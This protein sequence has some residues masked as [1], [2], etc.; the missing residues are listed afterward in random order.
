MKKQILA[1]FFALLAALATAAES[2]S[3][4][5]VLRDDQG[6]ALDNKNVVIEFRLYT[7]PTSDSAI[8][9]RSYAI[10]LDNDGLFNVELTDL[11]GSSISG[12]DATLDTALADNAS[13]KLYIGLTV[14][15]SSGEIRPRQ[16][17]LSVPV[18]S[19][20]RNVKNANGNFT[21]SGT[22]VLLASATV[23]EN[24][25]V[26]GKTTTRTLQVDDSTKLTGP[27]EV[28]GG[29]TVSDPNTGLALAA[30]TPFTING[31]SAVI[32]S[33]LIAIWSGSSANIPTGWAL[34]DGSNGTPDLRDRFVLGA[35]PNYPVAAQGGEY[36]HKLTVNEMPAHTHHTVMYG[37]DLSASWDDDNYFY[38]TYAK[39]SKNYNTPETTAT[40]GNA[41]H[42]NMPPYYALCYIMKK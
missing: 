1:S 12:L 38:T 3:Y 42:N 11:S 36:T 33:G 4:Q 8:W 41:P 16:Q 5:G 17:V 40:G 29:M 25:A 10:L 19:F 7:D 2:F 21:V 9:G 23:G 28:N 13:E 24:L 18:A 14:Q 20:A 31:V 27:V 6:A 15:G 34:C 30:G 22:A 39:Y 37:A 32:P 26:S 35:G